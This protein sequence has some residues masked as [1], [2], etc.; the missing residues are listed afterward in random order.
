MENKKDDL[1]REEDKWLTKNRFGRLEPLDEQCGGETCECASDQCLLD[2]YMWEELY[3]YQAYRQ[4][5]LK[6]K[7]KKNT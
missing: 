5:L 1:P 2:D 4:N 7:R 3:Q 6:A